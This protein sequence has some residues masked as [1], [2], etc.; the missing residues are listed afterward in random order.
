MV[1]P[2][3][4]PVSSVALEQRCEAEEEECSGGREG[5]AKK[6]LWKVKRRGGGVGG[7]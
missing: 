3:E 5:E 6:M 4:L 2:I 7:G 1:D